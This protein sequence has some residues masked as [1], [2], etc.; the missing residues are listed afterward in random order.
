MPKI[1]AT[2]AF[3][4]HFLVRGRRL[5]NSVVFASVT[6]LLLTTTVRSCCTHAASASLDGKTQNHGWSH[7]RQHQRYQPSHLSPSPS[8]TIIDDTNHTILSF[9]IIN[10]TNDYQ[11]YQSSH[12]SKT[13]MKHQEYIRI[14][15]NQ[16]AR[17]PPRYA[18]LKF[19]RVDTKYSSV[20]KNLYDK[21]G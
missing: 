11:Q 7:Q 2:L 19:T 5:H 16:Q 17:K 3:R 9:I 1:S 8:S 18:S 15:Q 21:K 13:N 14:M 20:S 12:Q 4:F 10:T 6:P